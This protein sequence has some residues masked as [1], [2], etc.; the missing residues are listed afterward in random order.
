MD[1]AMKETQE[2]AHGCA[3]SCQ[4]IN[5]RAKEGELGM[6][7]MCQCNNADPGRLVELVQTK[8]GPIQLIRRPNSAHC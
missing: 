3:N 4:K 2:L 8:S 6:H 1:G 5:L 7:R